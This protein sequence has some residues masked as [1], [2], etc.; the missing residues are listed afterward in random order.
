MKRFFKNRDSKRN[1]SGF[2]FL[3]SNEL[4]QVRGGGD[5]RPETKPKDIFDIN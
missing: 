3:T 4:L 2:Q 5:S 1:F